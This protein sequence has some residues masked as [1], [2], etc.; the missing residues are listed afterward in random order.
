MQILWDDLLDAFSSDEES[1]YFLDRETGEVFFVP[2][3]YE[4][5]DFWSEVGTQR[6]RYLRIPSFDYEQER[7]L[8]YEFIRQL[9]DSGLK[10]LLTQTFAGRSTFGRLDDILAFYPE[11]QE[12]LVRMKDEVMSGR[13]KHWLEEHDL[14]PETAGGLF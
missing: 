9:D 10:G 2:T 6:Q 3:G 14:Y 7:Y 1:I 12:R 5:G 8:V 4:D 13:I 11:E